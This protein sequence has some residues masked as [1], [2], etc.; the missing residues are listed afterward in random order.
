MGNKMKSDQLYYFIEVAKCLSLTKAAQR[1]GISQPSLSLSIKRLESELGVKILNRYKTGVTLTIA[2]QRLLLKSKSLIELWQ[3]TKQSV[4]DS[5]HEVE[6]HINLGCHSSVA[7]H[8]LPN[9]LPELLRKNKSLN[10][11]IHHGLSREINSAIISGKLDLGIVVNPLR[12]P[13]LVIIKLRN[14]KIGFWQHKDSSFDKGDVTL[15]CDSNLGQTQILINKYKKQGST[16][17]RIIECQSFELL[18]KLAC[19]KVGVAILPESI[20]ISK[21]NKMLEI[22]NPKL[23]YLDEICLVYRVENRGVKAIKA[24]VDSLKI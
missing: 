6:G 3:D 23:Y 12:H 15:L 2:G 16:F 4:F 11:S 9:S 24:L 21:S 19:Q 7:M 1:L 20:A 22:L 18:A 8:H 5:Q 14:D 10:I 13:D 17:S